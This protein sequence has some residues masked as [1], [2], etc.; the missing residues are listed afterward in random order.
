MSVS[1]RPR[2]TKAADHAATSDA[3]HRRVQASVNGRLPRSRRWPWTLLLLL[4]G[5]GTIAYVVWLYLPIGSGASSIHVL[6]EVKRGTLTVEVVERGNL[7]STKNVVHLCEV[8]SRVS[9]KSGGTTILWLIPA[10]SEVKEG[11]LLVELESSYIEDLEKAQ[12]I[13]YQNTL[14]ALAKSRADVETATKAII[15]YEQ[16]LYVRELKTL[17]ADVTVAEENLRR[18]QN[19]LQYTEG[20]YRGGFVNKLDVEAGEFAVRNT[21]LNLDKAKT[22]LDVL[23]KVS[24]DKN[25]TL[26]RGD[27]ESKQ[28]LLRSEEERASQEK[29]R[30]DSIIHQLTKCK[31]RAKANGMVVYYEAPGRFG[32]DE[33]DRIREGAV[34]RERQKLIVIPDLKRMQVRVLVNESKIDG[35]KKGQPVQITVDAFGDRPLTGRVESVAA[36]P[37]QGLWYDRDKRNY[38][39]LVNIDETFD[40]LKPGMTA[41]ASILL[42][43]VSE[44]L[45]VPVQCVRTV[46]SKSTCLVVHAD[47]Q[48]ET[49]VVKLGASNDS[50][51]QIIEGLQ[52]GE[53]V[54]Q[55]PDTKAPMDGASKEARREEDEERP[56][57]GR[58][59]GKGGN[60]DDEPPGKGKPQGRE[61]D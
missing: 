31:I 33:E 3:A 48:I 17:Q 7:E 23:V 38:A 6:H 44:V 59:P 47:G 37:E 14:S 22:A 8:E 21:Q 5:L 27:L 18:A 45:L 15:E 54:A 32:P 36:A 1:E 51:V 34:V 52:E 58:P 42:N 20:L 2:S 12:R 25:L 11:D 19:A 9:G 53:H 50:F 56:G 49:R 10:G 16:G 28:A 30:L 41:Q 60:D 39:V 57:K 29:A 13:T 46:G 24:K 61:R 35:V 55:T 43:H 4:I 26:L 40:G